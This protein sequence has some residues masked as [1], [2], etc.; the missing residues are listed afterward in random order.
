MN[1]VELLYA[2]PE[3]GADPELIENA[4]DEIQRL[5]AAVQHE[6]DVAEAYKAEADA[7]RMQVAKIEAQVSAL[8][9]A[10]CTSPWSDSPPC[11][12]ITRATKNLEDQVAEAC[13]QLVFGMAQLKAYDNQW[14]ALHDAQW[15][16]RQ[17]E[18][19][20]HLEGK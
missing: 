8:T 2:V 7:L 20:Q 3:T 15:L 12:G 4:A 14:V 16:I 11:S 1:I 19:R 6:K 13:A 9:T 18:W 17:G 5:Q 10:Q